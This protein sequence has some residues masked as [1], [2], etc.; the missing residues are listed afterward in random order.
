[1]R[2]DSP[3]RK[4]AQSV[5]TTPRLALIDNRKAREVKLLGTRHDF[6]RRRPSS[7]SLF[8]AACPPGCTMGTPLQRGA[9]PPAG[10]PGAGG[11]FAAALPGALV[12]ELLWAHYM[13][14]LSVDCE[15]NKGPAFGARYPSAQAK[16]RS[17]LPEPFRAAPRTAA[18]LS[19]SVAVSASPA[20]SGWCWG[21]GWPTSTA[22][23]SYARARHSSRQTPPLR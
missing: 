14:A 21:W 2:G 4:H 17:S 23:P 5:P 11:A 16:L 8:P 22:G 9:P 1:M 19:F 20:C 18:G 13:P 3:A 12:P 7:F 15:Q 10:R 6:S